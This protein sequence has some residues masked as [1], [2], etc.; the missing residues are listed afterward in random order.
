ML[1]VSPPRRLGRDLLSIRLVPRRSP[2]LVSASPSARHNHVAYGRDQAASIPV[3]DPGI[4]QALT[5]R[6]PAGVARVESFVVRCMQS[7]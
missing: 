5:A 2:L 4:A 7:S 3:S 1:S 6:P